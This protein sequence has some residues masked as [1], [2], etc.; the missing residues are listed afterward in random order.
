MRRS[1]SSSGGCFLI[2]F[3]AVSAHSRRQK[4]VCGSMTFNRHP[5]RDLCF[6]PFRVLREAVRIFLC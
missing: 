3:T 5:R 1:R 2:L 6:A 4:P